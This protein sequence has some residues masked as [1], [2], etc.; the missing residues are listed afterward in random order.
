MAFARFAA[1]HKGI[2]GSDAMDQPCVLQK[3]ER[4]VHRGR[5]GLFALLT[6]QGQQFVGLDRPMAAPHQLQHPAAER[7][8]AFTAR[9]AGLLGLGQRRL[10][11][12]PVIVGGGSKAFENGFPD[13]IH[14]AVSPAS[15]MACLLLSNASG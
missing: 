7:R 13:L 8:Q 11:A 5:R 10:D 9:D 4:A 6:Q 14:R 2:E 15:T 12:A 3:L 1:A